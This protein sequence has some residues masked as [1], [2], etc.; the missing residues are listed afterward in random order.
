MYH[1][2]LSSPSPSPGRSW[3][4]RVGLPQSLWPGKRASSSH[5]LQVVGIWK[6]LTDERLTAKNKFFSSFEG[7]INYWGDACFKVDL[8]DSPCRPPWGASST[9]KE[10]LAWGTL[11]L[12]EA[13]YVLLVRWW[14]G[15]LISVTMSFCHLWHMG[16]LF[17]C[18]TRSQQNS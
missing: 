12:R 7:E 5:K 1:F 9:D 6:V 15:I 14:K 8:T 16:N 10:A 18:S 3:G 4:F 2:P 11:T 17:S 13:S